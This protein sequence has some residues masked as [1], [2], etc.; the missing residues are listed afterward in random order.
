MDGRHHRCT[1]DQ[2]V[3]TAKRLG[4][5]GRRR[6]TTRPWIDVVGVGR[7]GRAPPTEQVEVLTLVSG[8]CEDGDTL[9]HRKGPSRIALRLLGTRPSSTDQQHN[10]D[11]GTDHYPEHRPPADDVVVHRMSG[12]PPVSVS[13][14]VNVPGPFT[15]MVTGLP[16][17]DCDGDEPPLTVMV[18]TPLPV[19]VTDSVVFTGHETTSE[20]VTA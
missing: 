16:D 5:G 14:R 19:P 8:P 3:P 9:A 12:V 15:E 1:F 7:G 10:H 13:V 18:F 17:L 2:I 6:S 4:V 11:S 20:Y